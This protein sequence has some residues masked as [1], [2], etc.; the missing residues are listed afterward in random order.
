MNKQTVG[1]HLLG[2]AALTA[3][4]ACASRAAGPK[5][6][7]GIDAPSTTDVRALSADR[8]ARG[9][10][11]VSMMGCNDCHT[12]L[13]IGPRGPQPDLERLL[14]GHP[15]DLAMPGAPAQAGPWMVASSGTNTAWSGPWGVSF[16]A[17]LTPDSET[18]IGRWTEAEFVGAMRT[19][20][21]RGKG[22]PILPP[23]PMA[24]FAALEDREIGDIFVYLQS[25]PPIHNPVP[26][27]VPPAAAPDVEAE[28]TAAR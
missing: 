5:P 26:A 3:T 7:P 2:T 23:M 19:G 12:P 6:A 13:L 17:N 24:S 1:L 25:I 15:A 20:R 11:L 9:A 18:G 27:P 16:T 4:L 10:R 21:H 8:V 28:E 22:R 14:S